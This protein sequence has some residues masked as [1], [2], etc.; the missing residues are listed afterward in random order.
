MMFNSCDEL[1]MWLTWSI[2]LSTSNK[3]KSSMKKS[4][5]KNLLIIVFKLDSIANSRHCFIEI[6]LNLLANF[7][8]LNDLKNLLNLIFDVDL[9]LTTTTSCFIVFWMTIVV[10]FVWTTVCSTV[11]F[12]S[13]S[14]LILTS[15]VF[16][17]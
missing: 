1:T 8:N 9:R 15:K 11:F 16:Y 4:N 10:S 12:V 14:F 3:I 13:R 2:I 7:S 6:E 17:L 5:L